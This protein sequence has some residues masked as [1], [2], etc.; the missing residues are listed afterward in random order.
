MK[1]LLG[2]AFDFGES[3]TS[4]LTWVTAAFML[5]LFGHSLKEVSARAFYASQN[6]WIPL[7]TA[8]GNV[9]LYAIT[10]MLLFRPLG[11]P[12]IALTDSIVF[13]LEALV[14]LYL[15]IRSGRASISAGS[16]PWRA[17]LALITA[18]AVTLLGVTLLEHR[19]DPLISGT[20]PMIAGFLL[21]LPWIWREVKLL[22][23][24]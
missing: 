18:G 12:G 4:L 10:G 22:A 9:L 17:L 20:L 16:T 11:A 5:G 24:L 1:P 8:G 15:L 6:A 13:T 3:G 7:A 19:V 23:R 21:S 14:L 2:L